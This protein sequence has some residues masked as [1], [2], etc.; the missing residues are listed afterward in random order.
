MQEPTASGTKQ[1][2]AATPISK[3]CCRCKETKPA[4]FFN[5]D[6]TR[7]SK[8]TA[9]CKSCNAANMLEWA[10]A[11]QERKK[12]LTHESH[13]RRAYGMTVA[14][15]DAMLQ[16]QGGGCAICGE[17]CAS[18]KR[19][20]IDHN[21]ATG[22]VRGLLCAHHNHGIGKFQD[23]PALLRAAAAYLELHETAP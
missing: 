21:H 18:G 9:W 2:P 12:R 10:A 15:Y 20:S 3:T 19:L 4:A 1:S 13:L 17:P 22:A 7:R 8:L 11:N 23:S 16:A 6:R 5:K 14:D